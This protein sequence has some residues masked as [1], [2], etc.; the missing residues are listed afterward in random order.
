MGGFLGRSNRIGHLH[1]NAHALK[2]SRDVD[3]LGVSDIGNVLLERHAED[4]HSGIHDATFEQGPYA[5]SC[6]ALAHAVVDAA[7][8]QNDFRMVTSLLSPKSQVVGINAN[9]VSAYKTWLKIQEIPFRRRGR[10]YVA[11]I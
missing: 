4:R 9:A 1:V 11:G 3:H 10:K 6:N 7:S 8:C 2:F 5:F